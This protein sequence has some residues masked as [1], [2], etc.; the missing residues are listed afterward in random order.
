ML[1]KEIQIVKRLVNVAHQVDE[2]TE[3][4][5]LGVESEQRPTSSSFTAFWSIFVTSI[6][7]IDTTLDVDESSLEYFPSLRKRQEKTHTRL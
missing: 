3:I 4:H 1:V 2:V 6:F 7:S 5:R